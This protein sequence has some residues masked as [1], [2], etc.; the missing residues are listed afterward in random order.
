MEEKF[1]EFSCD[2]ERSKRK[3]EDEIHDET[4]RNPTKAKLVHHRP[5]QMSHSSDLGGE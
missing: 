3:V 4:Q 5:M 1:F 2:Y